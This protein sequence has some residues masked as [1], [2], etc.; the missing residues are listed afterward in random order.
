MKRQSKKKLFEKL[1][2]LAKSNPAFAHFAN[3]NDADQRL[4]H[5]SIMDETYGKDSRVYV[6]FPTEEAKQAAVKCLLTAGFDIRNGWTR[7]NKRG[8]DVPVT[9][10]KGDRWW[11]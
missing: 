7:S 8:I 4:K 2:E 9:Y 5:K 10:F 11:E 6:L 1:A 3:V